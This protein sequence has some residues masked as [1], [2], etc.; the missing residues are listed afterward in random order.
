MST[1]YRASLLILGL[2]LTT[3]WVQAQSEAAGCEDH[4][5][6]SRYPGSVL[7]WCSADDFAEYHVATGPVTSYKNIDDWVDLEGKVYRHNYELYNATVT[8]NEVY[9]NYRN[10][11]TRAGFEILASGSDPSRTKR[12]EVGGS[13]WVGVAYIKNPLPQ[14][15]KSLL[16]AGSS[17]SGGYGHVAAKL[18]RPEGDVYAVITVYKQRDDR[19]ITQVDITEVAPL[20]D[21]KITVDV[22][23]LAREL[24]AKGSVALYGIYFDF[25][26]AIVKPESDPELTVIAEFLRANPSVS[27]YVVGHTDYEGSL[28]YNLELSQRRAAAV[29]NKLT[30]VHGVNKDRLIPQGVG[31][32]APKTTNATAEGRVKNR[33]VELVLQKE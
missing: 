22:D 24:A 6:I 13:T 10:A 21:G 20:D 8:M 30:M 4:P 5:M 14:T 23:Y 19:I 16:F 18:S 1:T 27:L 3:S 29:V 15:S 9:Q 2:I 7:V 26:R 32:L 33:R 25:D 17:S 28:D 11:L 12:N 31:P